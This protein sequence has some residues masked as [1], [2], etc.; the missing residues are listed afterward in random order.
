MYASP[1]GGSAL[2]QFTEPIAGFTTT[3]LYVEGIAPGSST[4]SWSYSG[5][6]D[7]ED[8]IQ[9][10]VFNVDIYP[11][12]DIVKEGDD[13][14][15]YKA[16]VTPSGLSSLN[17][18]WSWDAVTN[19]GNNPSVTYSAP[20]VATIHVDQAH[21]YAVPDARC[22]SNTVSDYQL[23]CT[24]SIG[25][26]TCSNSATMSVQL[27]DPA[28]E[29][30]STNL[31]LTGGPSRAFNSASNYWYVSGTGTLARQCAITTNWWLHTTSEF[32][33]KV[34]AHENQH[35]QD[36][37][38]G[39][40]GHK[41]VSVAEFHAR[42]EPLTDP[43]STGLVN[44]INQEYIQYMA[45]EQTEYNSLNAGFEVRAYNV[46]DGIAPDYYYSNCGRF[47]YP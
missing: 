19:G 13:S 9:V 41:F 6:S 14:G 36:I 44:K 27:A 10:T 29:A 46:S 18:S 21:W 4:L 2:A 40:D 26:T 30:T 38:N 32:T 42:I 35:G 16:I 23:L 31:T 47:I 20:N 39:F 45:D 24:V 12:W 43:T 7:C 3:N 15:D 8:E 5:Q 1:T 22:A 25:G 34:Q 11:I 37:I 28:A 33:A 17:Y